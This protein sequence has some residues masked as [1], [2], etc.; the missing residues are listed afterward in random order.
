MGGQR[1]P[2]PPPS[3]DAREA[4]ARAEQI[5]DVITRAKGGNRREGQVMMAKFVAGAMTDSVPLLAQG[6]TGVGKALAVDTP[7]PTPHGFVTMG[8]L[9]EGSTVLDETGQPCTVTIAHPVQHD[10]DCYRVEMVGGAE[11]VADG[12]HLWPVCRPHRTKQGEDPWDE[13]E[14]LETAVLA[15]R[16]SRGERYAI[17]DAAPLQL[18]EVDLPVD[19]YLLGVYIAGTNRSGTVRVSRRYFESATI[20]GLEESTQ[21]SEGCYKYRYL[22]P[23]QETQRGL[24]ALGV[25]PRNRFIPQQ[26]LFSGPDQRAAL[27]SGLVDA[28]AATARNTIKFSDV[29]ETVAQDVRT[30][31]STLGHRASTAPRFR[32][33]K[34]ITWNTSFTPTTQV[35]QCRK[36][37]HI[38]VPPTG[39]RVMS[40]TVASVEKV[41]SVPVRCI[42]VDSENSLFLAGQDMIPTHNSLAYLA[43]A[44]AARKSVV[45]APHTIALQ[46]QLMDDLELLKEAND[47]LISAG[48][49]EEE[50]T[51][52][53]LQGRSNY[54]CMEKISEPAGT[55]ASGT[56]EEIFTAEQAEP[57]S[58]LGSEVRNITKWV[59]EG[60]ETGNRSDLPFPTTRKAWDVVSVTSE[61]CAGKACPFHQ[62]G[63]CFAEIAK[64][65]AAEAQ[66]IVTN[67]SML[68]MAMQIPML[69]P[70]SV[71]AFVVDE[72]HEFTSVLA[73]SFG[74][75]VTPS[76]LRNAAKKAAAAL[77]S[78]D[79]AAPK[80]AEDIERDATRLDADLPRPKGQDRD[81]IEDPK[82]Q[83]ILED[84]VGG[85]SR[86][87]EMSKGLGSAD[88]EQKA[89][90]QILQQMLG[91]LVS[92]INRVLEGSTD[93]QVAWAER[94]QGQITFRSA[95]F[96]VGDLIHEKLIEPY[97]S[98][99]FTSATLTMANSFDLPAKRLGVRSEDDDDL[100]PWLGRMVES[101]FDYPTQGM[102]WFPDGMPVPST[103]KDAN[104]AYLEAVADV[105][106]RTA[107]AAGGRTL[108]L[109][110]SR[111]AVQAISEQV[112]REVGD[113]YPVLVQQP[114]EPA[115]PLAK[116]FAEDPRTILVGTRTFWT[117]VST[118]GPTCSAVVIDKLPFPSPAD[119]IVAARSEKAD[120]R[121]NGSSFTE[122]SLFEACL[123]VV[124][125]AGRLIRTVADTGLVVICDPRL[126]PGSNLKKFYGTQ[127]LR[128]LPPFKMAAGDVEALDWLRQIDAV[129]DDSQNDVQVEVAEASA[130]AQVATLAGK[131]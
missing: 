81:M 4:M 98:V 74:A 2:T 22:T 30:L 43:G 61:D 120:R 67:Q 129:A 24:D 109:C 56:Q 11:I 65:K 58:E 86:L 102:L 118:E 91:N 131:G 5:M 99:V 50:I 57:T 39:R 49:I 25:G 89:K 94:G 52:A 45:V 32:G 111:A 47:E 87:V 8:S 117:G 40:R 76:R 83:G 23:T 122:V 3:D 9:T 33:G 110:T 85:V 63:S 66:I 127:I 112:D 26:Y 28:G 121:R 13:Y 82:V 113:D 10:R 115:G 14:I 31:A 21:S 34:I 48:L 97:G 60:T 17:P 119:P 46:R 59:S 80:V 35:F 36:D 75:R 12:E 44:V 42:T 95:R 96:D 88:D 124:Q 128:S 78:H 18:P 130:E 90:K 70:E 71:D 53:D 79:D 68:A 92:D 103:K 108:V 29:S 54:V 72:A 107:R 105:V 38:D 106:T 126:N 55:Q 123:T 1:I 20:E 16:M 104:Q 84:L 73:D 7:I 41:R 27:L 125:G 77:A 6:G 51:T 101:P 93:H 114:G 19:P 64:A 116:R 37:E 69:L 15:D 100:V 62:E